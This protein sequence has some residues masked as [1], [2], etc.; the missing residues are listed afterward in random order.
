V[1]PW[2]SGQGVLNQLCVGR[3]PG[4]SEFDELR[5]RIDELQTNF[6]GIDHIPPLNITKAEQGN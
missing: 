4:I 5:Y 6:N 2:L 1:T 3:V